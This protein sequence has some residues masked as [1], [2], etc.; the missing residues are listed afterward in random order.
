MFY[1]RSDHP[2]YFQLIT[3]LG[4]LDLPWIDICILKGQ[5]VY[6]QRF[7]NNEEVW[8]TIKKKLTSFYFKYLL[9]EIVKSM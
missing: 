6:I 2:Y 4:V 5:D 1:I 8:S 7:T 3:L 9:P